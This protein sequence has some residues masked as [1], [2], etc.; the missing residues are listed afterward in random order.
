MNGVKLGYYPA[1][2]YQGTENEAIAD[3]QTPLRWGNLGRTLDELRKL[4]N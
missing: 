4:E 1:W 3:D 2:Y